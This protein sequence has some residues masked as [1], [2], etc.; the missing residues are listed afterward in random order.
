[1]PTNTPKQP[2]KSPDDKWICADEYFVNISAFERVMRQAENRP[3][4][5]LTRRIFDMLG[6][7]G[8]ELKDA[9]P[10]GLLKRDTDVVETK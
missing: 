5:P 8:P 7:D 4:P 10:D 1:M 6:M 3:L 9:P 2:K